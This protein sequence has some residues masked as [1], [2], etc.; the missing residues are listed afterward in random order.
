M[1]ASSAEVDL[2]TENVPAAVSDVDPAKM[3]VD[4]FNAKYPTVTAKVS[5]N[6]GATAT[7]PDFF[8]SL[9]FD[10]AGYLNMP[11]FMLDTVTA[12]TRK[13][14]N[15]LGGECCLHHISCEDPCAGSLVS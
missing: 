4:E 2:G 9:S 12:T 3:T 1:S 11:G 15:V 7:C 6:M 13:G 10:M 5:I 8:T 14:H